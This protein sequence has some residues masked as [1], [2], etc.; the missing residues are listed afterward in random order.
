MSNKDKV[1]DMGQVQEKQRR[2]A[3]DMILDLDEFVRE[4]PNLTPDQ[5]NAISETAVK[6]SGVKV[7]QG[8]KG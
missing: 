8:E 1:A 2:V 7:V 3:G 6:L 5:L 4:N